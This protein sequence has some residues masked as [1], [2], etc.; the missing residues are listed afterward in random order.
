MT[1]RDLRTI[2][3]GKT[4]VSHLTKVG[5]PG[6]GRIVKGSLYMTPEVKGLVDKRIERSGYATQNDYIN[7][8]IIKDLK[9]DLPAVEYI[10]QHHDGPT[11]EVAPFTPEEPPKGDPPRE[12]TPLSKGPWQEQFWKE[13]FGI[14]G[15]SRDAWAWL[16]EGELPLTEYGEVI[17]LSVPN[18]LFK[19][20]IRTRCLDTDVMLHCLNELGI[21]KQLVIAVRPPTPETPKQEAPK[22]TR[23]KDPV[24]ASIEEEMAAQRALDPRGT[25]DAV[26]AKLADLTSQIFFRRRYLRPP[27][28]W[29]NHITEYRQVSG[30][31]GV[32][33]F[34][35][36]GPATRADRRE[37]ERA[38]RKD[39][40]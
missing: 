36:F 27:R 31:K 35:S 30:K 11:E 22:K 6:F 28:H 34:E 23:P 5:H 8:L 37:A 33:G 10:E 16:G 9:G 7:D 14:V 25:N 12:E 39:S 24:I 20:E 32:S 18:G 13:V 3:P 17:E 19:E 4:R 26:K 1:Q 38:T 21:T 2:D 29:V 15:Q 40:S